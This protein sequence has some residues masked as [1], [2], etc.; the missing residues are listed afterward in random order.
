MD[1]DRICSTLYSQQQDSREAITPGFRSYGAHP[2]FFIVEENRQRHGGNR[3]Q[4]TDKA[5]TIDNAYH[6]QES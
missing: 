5:I 4:N 2:N 1:I 3:Q 6:L